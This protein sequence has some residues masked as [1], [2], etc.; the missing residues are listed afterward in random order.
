MA[1]DNNLFQNYY[2][3]I[4]W[5]ALNQRTEKCT[6]RFERKMEH[7]LN[8]WNWNFSHLN[9]IHKDI[10]SLE[11]KPEMKFLKVLM[12][13]AH[14]YYFVGL[15]EKLSPAICMTWGKKQ[16]LK[17]F[18]DYLCWNYSSKYYFIC[19]LENIC[20]HLELYCF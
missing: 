18:W 1:N 12:E 13:N 7:T 4:V 3:M 16:Q 10:Y 19:K 11:D 6:E 8:C 9:S 15:I 20:F 14:I 2:Y 5:N 17:L